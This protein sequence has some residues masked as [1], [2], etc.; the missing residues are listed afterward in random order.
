MMNRY[1]GTIC[2]EAHGKK[3]EGIMRQNPLTVAPDYISEPTSQTGLKNFRRIPVVDKD[4]LVGMIS[5]GDI[6]RGLFFEKGMKH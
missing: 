5:I 2:V 4:R 6:N 1:C 3:L